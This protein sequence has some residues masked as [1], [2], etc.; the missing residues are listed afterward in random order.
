VTWSGNIPR[1]AVIGGGITGLAAAHRL[2]SSPVQV[3]VSVFEASRSTGGL[4]RT[5]HRDGFLIECGPDSFITNKPAALTLCEELGITD[6]LIR[7]NDSFRK[8]LVLHRQRP[9]PVPEGFMLMAPGN[10]GAILKTPV[11]SWAGKIRLLWE[12]FVSANSEIDDESL[13]SFVVRRFGR[14]AFEN[15]VQPLV[16]GIYTADPS[17]LSL[18]ATLPRFLDM[19]R[20]YG[21]IIRAMLQ[22]QKSGSAEQASSGSGARYGLFTTHRDGLGAIIDACVQN[23]RASNQVSIE[24]GQRVA[25]LRPT[26]GDDGWWHLKIRGESVARPFDAVIVTLPTHAI[27]RLLPDPRCEALRKSLEQF[28]YASSAIVVTGHRLADFDHPLDAF[29]LVIPEREQRDILAV[30]FSSRKFPN[31]APAGSVLLRTFVGGAMH[32]ELM[33]HDDDEM[34]ALVRRELT[35]T[36]GLRSDPLFA[37][38]VRYQKAM[39]QYHVGHMQRV[40]DLR[41]NAAQFAGLQ[42]AGSTYDGVGLPDSIRSGRMAA[43]AILEDISRRQSQPG[44]S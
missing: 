43:D 37:E 12:R 3:S 4:I 20:E 30:S 32:P 15:L 14:E 2:A 5:E 27:V 1:I 25:T 42:L 33:E 35:S 23:C 13:E 21:S 11:L 31:R 26:D 8:S 22:Q 41:E 18:R 24:C 44:Q 38:V 40:Q 28:E 9:E 6:Q 16:G 34:V 10:L 36:L 7:T 29:G 39:P 19:E 17:R